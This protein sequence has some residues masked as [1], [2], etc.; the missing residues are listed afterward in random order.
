MTIKRI[1]YPVIATKYQP[2]PWKSNLK[3]LSP[4]VKRINYLLEK[5]DICC[6]T[7]LRDLAA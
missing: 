2:K 7:L 3:Q 6:L 4:Q 5:P 1:I